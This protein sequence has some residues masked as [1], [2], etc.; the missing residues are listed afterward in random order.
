M[1]KKQAGPKN[2]V[3][4]SDTIE[5]QGLVVPAVGVPFA[6]AALP[7]AAAAGIAVY[8]TYQEDIHRIVNSLV[9]KNG[10]IPWS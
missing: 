3:E 8:G 1:T 2:P 10:T 9:G 7:A 4:K 6:A 5:R